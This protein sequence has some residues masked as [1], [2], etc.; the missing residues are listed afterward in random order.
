MPTAP[1]SLPRF[2]LPRIASLVQGGAALLW[3]PQAALLAW[4]VQAMLDG[5]GWRAALAP[6]IT[7]CP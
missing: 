2:V 1:L 3:L 6:A 5:A 7:D 4:A